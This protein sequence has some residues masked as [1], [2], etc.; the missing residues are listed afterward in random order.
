[1]ETIRKHGPAWAMFILRLILGSV[2][3]L[4]GSQKVLGLFG[5]QGLSGFA[6]F[7][8]DKLGMPTFLGYLAALCEFVGG[9]MVLLGVA[10]E[11]GA[12]LIVPVMLVAVFK[13]HW[14]HGY[15]GQNNGFEYPLNLL[16]VCLALLIGGPGKLALWDPFRKRRKA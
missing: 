2:F 11:V 3:V 13:V 1:M 15:F 12:L 10:T 8:H 14:A 5:G 4:H 9:G 6:G 7:V 16:L